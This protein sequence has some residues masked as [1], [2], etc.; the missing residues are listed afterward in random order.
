MDTVIKTFQDHIAILRLNSGPT[1]PISSK[2]VNELS[3]SLADIKGAARGMVLCG[4]D[5][6]FSA[7]FNLPELLTFDRPAMGDFL[8]RFNQLCLALFTE[9]IPTVCALSGHAVAG[10]NILALTCDYRYAASAERKIGL[11]ELKIGLPVPYLADLM[12]RHT[13]GDRSASQMIF[14]GEFMAF[15]DAKIIGLVDVVG[16]PDELD[17]FTLE[18]ISRIASH[19]G[20]AFSAAKANKVEEII[21][22]YEKNNQD[23]NDAFLDCWFS[24]RAQKNLRDAAVKF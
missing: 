15:S 4:G 11:N 10:G 19:P 14:S 8:E 18:R 23:K 7:G 20:R 21:R 2:L 5:K 17:D 3:Q 6:F 13:I 1:N 12:L 24:D 9:P 22:R 16:S